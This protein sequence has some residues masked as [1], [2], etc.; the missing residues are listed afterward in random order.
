[1]DSESQFGYVLNRRDDVWVAEY[2]AMAG[3]CEV[4]MA[5]DRQSE[6]DRLASLALS[7][8]RR[9]E[10]KFSRYRD[11]NIVHQ[12]NSSNGEP[13]AVDDETARLLEYAKQVH[14]LSEGQF[15][16]TSGV[17]RRA[18]VFR[19]EVVVPDREFIDEL[20]ERVGW[21]RVTWDGSSLTMA[22]GMEIDFGGIGKEYAVDK[23]AGMLFEQSGLSL[24]VNF[25]GDIRTIVAEGSARSWLVGIEDPSVVK[26]L[27]GSSAVGHA[28]LTNGA[29]ATSGD[30][31]RFC[32]VDGKRL[33]HILNP[34]TGWPVAGA[35]RTVTVITSTCVEAGFLATM[36][37]L[38]GAGAEAFLQAQGVKYHVI[39]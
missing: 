39:W 23:V 25:G 14:A 10:Q 8:T 30:T 35:P 31:N 32:I 2:S 19:G 16:I 26:G 15:D 13:V 34:K 9:I 38:S 21:E 27:S 4:H 17:L 28:E 1:M 3:P 18:W 29:I 24:M 22:P 7:E 36:A 33:G 11:D 12:I 20:L 5:T 6:A 37:V